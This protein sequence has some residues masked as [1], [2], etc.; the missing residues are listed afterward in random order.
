VEGQAQHARRDRVKILMTVWIGISL[1][2]S[3]EFVIIERNPKLSIANMVGKTVFHLQEDLT[4]RPG[5]SFSYYLGWV[6]LGLM[7]TM[8]VYM[9]RKRLSLMRRWGA[10]RNWLNFHIFCGLLGPTLILFHCGFKVRGLV[11]ISFWS[12]LISASSGIIGRYFYGQISRS[13]ND[14][15]NE[16]DALHAKIIAVVAKASIID[17]EAKVRKHE[18][19][20]LAFVGGGKESESLFEVLYQSLMG[21]LR[22]L[23][24]PNPRFPGLS[25]KLNRGW[26]TYSLLKRKAALIETF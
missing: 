23:V 7:V 10:L 22:L 25:R 14:L 11:G 8:N 2:L 13:K 12:M 19:M 17:Y 5:K 21:D 26:I 3:Y 9:L 24:N 1:W 4:M 6:G 18:R 20:L 16:A 15:L